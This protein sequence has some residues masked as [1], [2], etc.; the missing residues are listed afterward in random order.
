MRLKSREAELTQGQTTKNDSHS[1]SGAPRPR[2]SLPY[3]ALQHGLPFQRNVCSVMFNQS[4]D[5][6]W[7]QRHPGRA[8]EMC[9]REWVQSSQRAV[10]VRIALTSRGVSGANREAS[11]VCFCHIFPQP[12][13][14]APSPHGD[15]R[16]PDALGFPTSTD[17]Q[18]LVMPG[19]CVCYQD[20]INPVI[21]NQ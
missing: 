13:Q 7:L 16:L 11:E 20:V 21:D 19:I 17:Q 2:S 9:L 5:I 1:Y 4:Q 15:T 6:S 12:T 10:T 18:W 3:S 8:A 14:A